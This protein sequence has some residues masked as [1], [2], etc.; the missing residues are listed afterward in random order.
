MLCQNS[1]DPWMLSESSAISGFDLKSSWP[2][3]H[4]RYTFCVRATALSLLAVFTLTSS[5]PPCLRV[6]AVSRVAKFY[7]S[8]L[9]SPALFT[10]SDS[11]SNSLKS[12]NPADGGTRLTML[13]KALFARSV[14]PS[15]AISNSDVPCDSLVCHSFR[16]R[17][18][19][20]H[21]SISHRRLVGMLIYISV[22]FMNHNACIKK[23]YCT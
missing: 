10:R 12:R 21:S 15:I 7:R 16:S 1:F 2:G 17:G 18:E 19:H 20:G 6:I 14:C 9:R 4:I 13:H 3:K 11:A 23:C 22:L 8:G 5:V